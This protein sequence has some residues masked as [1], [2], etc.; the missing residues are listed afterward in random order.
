MAEDI[1]VQFIIQIAGKPATNVQKA[2][3][4]VNKKLEESKD[5]KLLE[6]E[7]LEPELE[8]DTTL[9]SGMIDAIARFDDLEKVFNFILDYTPNSI[10]VIEPENIKLDNARLTTML[11]HFS[12]RL[13][14]ATHQIRTLNAHVHHLNKKIQES[15]VKK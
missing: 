3:D 11:N 4:L 1:E 5:F 7:V 9:Y 6:S 13:L 15:Q 8:E 14:G 2:L 10:E 12:N